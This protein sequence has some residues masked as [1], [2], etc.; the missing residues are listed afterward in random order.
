MRGINAGPG[1]AAGGKRQTGVV[2][3]PCDE[4]MQPITGEV[5]NQCDV[6]FAAVTEGDPPK[7]GG[8]FRV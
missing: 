1:R 8:T 5:T 4:G 3:G 7:R 2:E 6:G